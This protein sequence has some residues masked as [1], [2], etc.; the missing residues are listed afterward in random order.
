MRI[1]CPAAA[2]QLLTV[3]FI[4]PLFIFCKGQQTLTVKLS[5]SDCRKNEVFIFNN[6]DTIQFFQ[7]NQLISEINLKNYRKWPILID[8]FKTGIFDVSY[9]NLYGN[10]VSKT[11]IIPDTATSFDLHLCTDA[12]PEYSVNSLAR[13]KN[14]D[15]IKISFSRYGCFT[16]DEETLYLT[17]KD[18]SFFAR[19]MS[20]GKTA[21][22]IMNS[23]RMN[24]FIRFENEIQELRDIIGCT[25]VDTYL[26]TM[27]IRTLKRVDGGCSWNGFHYLKKALFGET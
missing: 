6:R 23:A 2:K 20:S 18:N 13:L 10:K 25:S 27:G 5:K 26:I 7:H 11:I 22:V 19:L 1:N 21:S 14:Y 24:A 15:T 17:K 8:S 16:A 12:L 4:C 9:K 3:T